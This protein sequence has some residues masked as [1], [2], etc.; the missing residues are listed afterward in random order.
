MGDLAQRQELLARLRLPQ[1]YPGRDNDLDRFLT[2]DRDLYRDRL[3]QL[4]DA[5]LRQEYLSVH[6]RLDAGNADDVTQQMLA[7]RG[8]AV[9][10]EVTARSGLPDLAEWHGVLNHHPV[11]QGLQALAAADGARINLDC[12]SV[13]IVRP[14]LAPDGHPMSPAEM[15]D[16]VRA[17]FNG[18]LERGGVVGTFNSGFEQNIPLVPD[19][20]LDGP[21]IHIGISAAD[22]GT[23][24][25]TE[26]T[27]QHFRLSTVFTSRDFE[28]P[29]TGSREFGFE[30]GPVEHS[31][32]YTRGA[33]RPTGLIDDLLDHVIF[34]GGDHIWRG[35]QGGFAAW[36]H[37]HGGEAIVL[38]PTIHRVAWSDVDTFLFRHDNH[39]WEQAAH[40]GLEHGAPPP[41]LDPLGPVIDLDAPADAAIDLARDMSLDIAPMSVELLPLDP[42]F[43]ADDYSI[44]YPLDPSQPSAD[45]DWTPANPEDAISEGM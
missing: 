19:T 37:Q 2:L 4:P 38:S 5:Q 44:D 14:P 7:Y 31:R 32:I 3:A 45:I 18:M 40:A 36:V 25:L 12:Y 33:D 24:A 10:D 17:D 16:A 23:V 29:V 13:E 30:T 34:A 26:N 22:D 43:A 6:D 27:T 21:Y 41:L 39:Y 15:L 28:H 8:D 11:A 9:A 35:W 1:T 20:P 42:S